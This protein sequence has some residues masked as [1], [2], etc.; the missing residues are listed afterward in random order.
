MIKLNILLLRI[1]TKLLGTLLTFK[2]FKINSSI[3]IMIIIILVQKQ[4]HYNYNIKY[5]IYL[6]KKT[7]HKNNKI[8]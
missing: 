8:R 1:S 4:S 6:Q 3:N 5:R 2:L 7:A